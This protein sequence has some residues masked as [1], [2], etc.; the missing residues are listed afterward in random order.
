MQRYFIFIL[1]LLVLMNGACKKYLNV[2]E[3][4]NNPVNVQESLL[5][6]PLE[7]STSTIVAGGSLTVSNNPT[8]AQTDA[9]WMQ[10]IAL[11]QI[12]PALDEYLIQPSN[13]DAIWASM[14]TTILENARIL[15]EKAE[16]HKNYSY[17]V[18]AKIL[19]AYNLGIL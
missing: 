11:V 13:V 15:N 16:L 5:L 18:I 10:Q 2:N 1:L 7:T 9:F 17:A 3:D 8:V 6:L 19:T 12:P 4:P 14:Y